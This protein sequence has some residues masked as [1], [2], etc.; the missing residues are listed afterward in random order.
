MRFRPLVTDPRVLEY[1]CSEPWSD[2]RTQEFINKQI[3]F[4]QSR[5]WA[6]W[7]VIHR[8]DNVLVGFFGFGD[9][10]RPMCRL[11]GVSSP[12]IGGKDWRPR[13]RRP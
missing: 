13:L 8:K 12:N 4:T 10:I 2:E 3:E 9:E 11:D 6:G 5:G 7:P 1:V